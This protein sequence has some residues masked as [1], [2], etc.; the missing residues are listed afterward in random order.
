MIQDSFINGF[1]LC[2]DDISLYPTRSEYI[3]LHEKHQILA[4]QAIWNCLQK[5]LDLFQMI[6]VSFVNWFKLCKDDDSLYPTRSEYLL[7]REKCQ[8]FAF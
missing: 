4:I 3:L 5:T 8:I 7:L 6:E 2:K 1:K